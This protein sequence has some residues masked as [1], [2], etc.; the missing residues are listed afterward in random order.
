MLLRS[1]ALPPPPQTLKPTKQNIGSRTESN[2]R[3]TEAWKGWIQSCNSGSKLVHL[4]PYTHQANGTHQHTS[5]GPWAELHIMMCSFLT[6]TFC[7]N[8]EI[9]AHPKATLRHGR[10]GSNH[11][12]Q[13]Q[14]LFIYCHTPT[15]QMEHTSTHQQVHGQ[16]FTS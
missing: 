5:T 14:S 13:K 4:L 16:S 7:Q 15:R 1:P 8:H 9:L 2:H 3:L 6:P 10:D 12:T 11:A